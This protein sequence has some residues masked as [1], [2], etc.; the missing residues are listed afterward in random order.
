MQLCFGA[1]L[2]ILAMTA[3]ARHP[4]RNGVSFGRGL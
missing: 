2:A 3:L 4:V 1:R